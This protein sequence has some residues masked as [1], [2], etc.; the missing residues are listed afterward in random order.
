[1]IRACFAST[2]GGWVWLIIR[3]P[4]V[5]RPSSRARREVLLG[6]VG[7]GAVRGDPADRAAVVLRLRGCRPWCR[8]R[9]AS[10][11]RSW[12]CFAVSRRDL[13][14]L[15]LR[16]VR[17]A[18]VEARPAEP[19]AVGH[20]E[21]RHPGLVEGGDDRAHL[22]GGELVALVVR[23]VAQAGVG[24]ADVEVV[25]TTCGRARS[26]RGLRRRSVL[27]S[28]LGHPFSRARRRG[29]HDVEVAGV[30]RQE[31][32]RALDLEE[33]AHLGLAT[34]R[35]RRVGRTAGPGAAGSR[36]RSPARPRPSGA[37]T[38]R[39]RPGPR[40]TPPGRRRRRSCRA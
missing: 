29:G 23:A 1:M 21:H 36:A 38:R 39:R 19:V 14:Q 25:A 11:R 12:R 18:V 24:Q 3:K 32:A 8:R 16:G 28:R 9:A 26:A 15:L 5:S 2:S 33:D 13:D 4:T 37:P 10:G 22:L 6:G 40:R 34:G 30:R 35:R 27:T 7:L 20:L 17:E 31:V